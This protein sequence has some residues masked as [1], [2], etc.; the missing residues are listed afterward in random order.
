MIRFTG[1][2]FPALLC[3]AAVPEPRK[4][5]FNREIRPILSDRCFQCHGP[6]EANRRAA[7]RLD[8][9][10][11]LLE[12]K[13]V[14]VPGKPE[15]SRLIKR[16]HAT[17]IPTRMPP[18]GEPLKD[19]QKQ[20][21]ERWIREGAVWEDH[22]AYLPPERPAAPASID[23]LIAAKLK[24][25]G[26]APSP[27][28]D[29]PTL[30]RRLTLD[31]TG[32]PPT[33]A[34]LAAFVN[35]KSPN[36]WEAQIDRLLASPRYGERLALFWLDLARYADTHGFHIDSH[37]DMWR[38]RDWVI[39]SFNGNQ[40]FDQFIVEQLAGDLLPNPTPDQIL[41]TG[42]NRNHMINFEG[43]AIPEE[44]H[45]EYLVDRV[46]TTAT[47]FLATTM[48]CARCHDHKYDPLR[49]KEF[50]QFAA[51][52]NAVP[53]KG[54]DGQRGNAEPLLLFPKGDQA[55]RK[56]F[57]ET[58]IPEL[59]K[60]LD[61]P[62]V[63]AGY[64][65]WQKTW[66]QPLGPTAGLLA[67]YEFEGALTDSSGHYL[68]GRSHRDEPS[69]PASPTGGK[70]LELN[71]RQ[72]IELAPLP[73][74]QTLAFWFRSGARTG[75]T[76]ILYRS[77][78]DRRGWHIDLE[79]PAAIPRLRQTSRLILRRVERWPDRVWEA[80]LKQPVFIKGRNENV[81][82]HI[83]IADGQ[84]FINGAPAEVEVTRDTLTQPFAE[85]DAPVTIGGHTEADRLRGRLDDLRF[86][87]RVLT[88]AEIATLAASAPLP[89]SRDFYFAKHAPAAHQAIWRELDVLK[90]E[91]YNLEWEIESA[92]VMSTDQ[93]PRDTYLLARGDYRNPTEKV[94][95]GVPSMLPPLPPGA[96]PD[97]L[98]LAR[99]LADPRHPLT[100]RV[101]VNRFW[102][103]LFAAG[104]VKTSEDFGS[105]G[106]PP[107]NQPLLD[108]LA[109]DFT[110]SGWN[111]KALLKQILMSNAYQQSSK[112]TPLLL[113]KDPENRL[114]A[115]GPRH[116][117][118]AEMIRDGAL[119]ASG[120]LE[121]R[122]GGP[123]V[124][125]YQPPNIW[126]DI[127]FGAEFSAQTY[128]QS[129]G[130]DLYRRSMYTFWKR[131]APNPALAAFDAPDREKCVSRR[132]LTNTPLQALVLLNDPT[133]I[134]AA[135]VLAERVILE[136]PRPAARIEHAFALVLAR[137]PSPAERRVIEDLARTT[138]VKPGIL[139]VG[140]RKPNPSINAQE[141]AAW[142][143]AMSAI[144]NLDE[145]ITKE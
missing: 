87:N 77:T 68:H 71:G 140:A 51:F 138:T 9:K 4:I 40:P 142:T 128:Q 99:W 41:A 19:P 5:D 25:A 130:A 112:L 20:A 56:A 117:L 72:E 42:F 32:L 145:A 23:S 88:P 75:K 15:E 113:E 93:K 86:Y 52:F 36:A 11:G 127:A 57:V 18:S 94:T 80:R 76:G 129:T 136:S 122:T 107:V 31:L 79:E 133:Y 83:A 13:G 102:Q 37:R 1:W 38:W 143:V 105:Q 35:D 45:V 2:L 73:F 134:E 82:T 59:E 84:W 33:P 125:P 22:W 124:F 60:Q 49:Q 116:R 108:L 34:E 144:L 92:M 65:A 6:D 39:R 123:S 28:A 78:P 119:F 70:A 120:L 89:N 101:A 97:R 106:E 30:L 50:Y 66:R 53:E 131:T 14:I 111:V 47:V 17:A 135:R 63:K 61:A 10:T 64:E 126:E 139:S 43:G 29:K 141:L 12:R 21:L 46:D 44:Y 114:L 16:I 110:A 27:K 137:K 95:P 90:T 7:L 121:E 81:W 96:N 55:E 3:A 85:V 69:F 62:A 109:T 98:A 24:A 91:R 54:L 48:A 115:R 8:T 132:P 26:L 74:P 100:A 103:M 67:H 58:R 118:P 104:L